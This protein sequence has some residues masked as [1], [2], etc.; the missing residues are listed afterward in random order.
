MSDSKQQG[1]EEFFMDCVENQVEEYNTVYLEY[2]EL[3]RTVVVKKRQDLID[4]FI[5]LLFFSKKVNFQIF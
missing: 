2:L 4:E 5:F 1:F 3:Q